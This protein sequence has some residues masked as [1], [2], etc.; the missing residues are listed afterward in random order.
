M[1]SNKGVIPRLKDILY[2]NAR[3]ILDVGC[4]GLAPSDFWEV[5]S[6]IPIKYGIDINL[7]NIISMREKFPDGVFICMDAMLLDNIH[8][9]HFDIVHSQ[10]VIEHLNK[11]EASLLIEIME[12]LAIKQI[13]IGTPKGFRQPDFINLP[14]YEH[15]NFASFW[16]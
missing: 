8:L 14:Y 4:G 2:S 3:S 9:H 12:K 15:R 16:V 10:N 13:I 1:V 6:H 11:T 5:F 7:E